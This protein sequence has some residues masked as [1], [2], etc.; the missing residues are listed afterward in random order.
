MKWN[1]NL[2]N[3]LPVVAFHPTARR[4][5]RDTDQLS[6]HSGK[7]RVSNDDFGLSGVRMITIRA[8]VASGKPTTYTIPH[9]A[10]WL[11]CCLMDDPS[12][13]HDFSED[14]LHPSGTRSPHSQG[15]M[16]GHRERARLVRDSVDPPQRSV[17]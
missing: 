9:R 5:E 1:D 7:Q 11:L 17:W 6:E 4:R 12:A 8:L 15:R 16:N 2:F 13:K 10:L 3:M 14:R